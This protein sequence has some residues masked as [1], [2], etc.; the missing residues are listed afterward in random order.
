FSSLPLDSVFATGSDVSN[1]KKVTLYLPNTNEA[2]TI[3]Q[4]EALTEVLTNIRNKS[5]AIL[6]E[7]SQTDASLVEVVTENDET[8]Q[9]YIQNDAIVQDVEALFEEYKLYGEQVNDQ[10]QL[11]E[12]K[13]LEK[14]IYEFDEGLSVL[15]DKEALKTARETDQTFIYVTLN[16]AVE[17]VPEALKA[18]IEKVEDIQGFVAIDR[19]IDLANEETFLIER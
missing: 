2:L 1:P 17:E 19:V 6:L 5:D 18:S 11:F 7:E 16:P 10:I 3:Y 13:T 9:G 4:D 15:I 14:E 8:I 12:D